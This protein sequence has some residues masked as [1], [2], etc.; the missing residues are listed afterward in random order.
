MRNFD[1]LFEQPV[2]QTAGLPAS[3]LDAMKHMRQH[4]NVDWLHLPSPC[5]NISFWFWEIDLL[6]LLSYL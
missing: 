5:H 1:V 6:L 2:E 3:N 4:R